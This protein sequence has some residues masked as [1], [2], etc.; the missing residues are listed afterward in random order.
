M[1]HADDTQPN[2]WG[3]LWVDLP[4]MQPSSGGFLMRTL[5]EDLEM[6][7]K[8]LTMLVNYQKLL[9]RKV[10]R[11]FNRMEQYIQRRELNE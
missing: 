11:V 7:N 8:E 4:R 1:Q 5:L 2:V 3:D 9:E 10:Q 6:L